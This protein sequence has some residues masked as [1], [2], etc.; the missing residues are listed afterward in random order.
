MKYLQEI[1]IKHEVEWHRKLTLAMACIVFF[2]LGAPLGAIIKKGGF[3]MPVLVSV[4][5]FIAF[6]IISVTTEKMVKEAELS[7]LQ[8]MW[9]ANAILLPIGIYLI[10][11]AN[12]DSPLV[13]W[14]TFRLKNLSEPTFYT[15]CG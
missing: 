10:V 9:T 12:S 14:P 1:A 11:T 8:G 7:T 15:L 3:G 2:L 13:R 5:F 6:H 4:G